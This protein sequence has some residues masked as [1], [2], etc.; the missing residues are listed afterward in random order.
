MEHIFYQPPVGYAAD[1]IPYYENGTYYLFYLQD[2]RDTEHYGEG[3]PWFLITTQDFVHFTEYGEVLPRGTAE[4][5]DLYVFTG[6][7]TRIGDRYH[8]YYTGHNPHFR[9]QGKPEQGVMHAVSDDLSDVESF[10][11]EA[12]DEDDD[13]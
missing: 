7:V 1:F 3:T 8:I 13:D 5:Q 9:A 10:L 2:Y 12:F 11:Y 4:E 6:S